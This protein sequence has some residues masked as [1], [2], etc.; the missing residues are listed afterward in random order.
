MK[1]RVERTIVEEVV[2]N[3]VS[4]AR[5]NFIVHWKGGTHTSFE[6]ARLSKSA[7]QRTTDEDLEIIRKMAVRY[8]DDAIARVL[9]K[10]G[11][12]TGR[13]CPGASSG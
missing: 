1:G 2:A 7:A 13:E 5:L 11:R 12:R 9:N 4:K 10:L 3:E 8:G 6:L